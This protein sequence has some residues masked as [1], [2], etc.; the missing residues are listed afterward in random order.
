MAE[1]PLL[2]PWPDILLRH[3]GRNTPLWPHGRTPLRPHGRI[4]TAAPWPNPHCGAMGEHPPTAPRPNPHCGTM[5]EPPLRHLAEPTAAPWPNPYCSTMAEP[6][7][8]HHS[9]ILTVAPWPNPHCGTMAE[10][11]LPPPPGH[12]IETPW[13][14]NPCRTSRCGNHSAA[15]HQRSRCGPMAGPGSAAP[16]SV[17]RLSGQVEPSHAVS[18]RSPARGSQYILYCR[19]VHRRRVPVA[20]PPPFQVYY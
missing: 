6:P 19:D 11:P 12:S 18:H 20:L 13:P 7:L 5:A 16:R 10:H 14:D 9:R 15:A 3:C 1:H 17:D 2:A 4:P 8:R